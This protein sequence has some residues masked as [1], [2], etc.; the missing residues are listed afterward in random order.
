MS[1]KRNIGLL[2]AVTFFH[3]LIPA[4]VIERL[5]WAERGLG[6]SAV[7]ACEVIY[8]ISIVV[9]EVPSGVLA[10]RVGR[11]K[12]LLVGA[13]LALV[14]FV[15]LLNAYTFWQF[16]LAILL[17]GIGS[18]C[19][20][21]TLNAMLYDSL[22][23]MGQT[24]R[25]EW[26][27]GRLRAVESIAAIIAGLSGGLLAQWAGYA[28]NYQLS[29]I[30]CAFAVLCTL[31][32]VEPKRTIEEEEDAGLSVWGIL[33]NAKAFFG[34]EAKASLIF[35][36]ATIIAGFIIY[37]D[38]FWQLYLGDI[39]YPVGI[40]GVVLTAF[41]LFRI[42]GAA[43]AGR[44]AGKWKADRMLSVLSLVAALGMLAAA[45]SRS[46]WGIAAMV[47]AVSASEVMQV[48]ATG[49]LHHRADDSARA[50]IESIGSLVERVSVI[51]IGFLFAAIAERQSLFSAY[52]LLAALAFVCTG[53]FA[54][55]YWR[56]SRRTTKA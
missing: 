34:R 19:T 31:L 46:L 38:E 18:A 20:S 39:G 13:V 8:A 25:F 37:V 36:H 22:A 10:D 1:A 17:T 35:V 16:G 51:G 7:V 29:I 23:E 50:T 43:A 42:A 52:G 21:G 14:E 27:L 9:M 44:W 3:N 48:V 26:A 6:V 53:I 24:G 41:S 54:L 28:F 4:Y 40:F 47:I 30:S 2:F 33:R 32:L 55:S 56:S 49:Y 12:M 11:R 5:F 15:L 45:L